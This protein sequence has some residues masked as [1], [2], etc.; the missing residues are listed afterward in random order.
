MSS[1]K[2]EDRERES[3]KGN[4]NMKSMNG[5]FLEVLSIFYCVFFLEFPYFWFNELWTA[6]NSYLLIM[7]DVHH[8]LHVS[9]QFDK[10]GENQI[11]EK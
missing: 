4:W 8:N 11:I 6:L 5:D 10:K 3:T 2:I 9:T 1:I 7:L